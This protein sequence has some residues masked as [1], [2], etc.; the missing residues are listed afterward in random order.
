MAVGRY[1][2]P[3]QAQFMNTY[4]P[5]PFQE[6]LQAGVAKQG[7]QDTRLGQLDAAQQA[8]DAIRYIP[9][10][11]DDKYVNSQVLPVINEIVENYSVGRDLTDPRVFREMRNQMSSID[12]NRVSRVQ[13]SRAAWDK[14]QEARNKLK[15]SG[16]YEPYLDNQ[17]V[18]N[19][20]SESDI[21][22]YSPSAKVGFDLTAESYFNQLRDSHLYTDPTTGKM[23]SGVTQNKV[24]QVAQANAVD[25]L[26]S[27]DGQQA[28]ASLRYQGVEGSDLD[29]ATQYLVDR[30]QEF[31][32][33]SVG[34]APQHTIARQESPDY[35]TG[36]EYFLPSEPLPDNQQ[37]YK[38][39]SR[40]AEDLAAAGDEVK[41]EQYKN[42][43]QTA[44]QAKDEF[45]SQKLTG[46]ETDFDEGINKLFSQNQPYVDMSASEQENL[47]Q[48]LYKA[49]TEDVSV[50]N[51]Y[52][53]LFDTKP[54]MGYYTNSPGRNRADFDKF[55]GKYRKQYDKI[56]K[57]A[58]EHAETVFQSYANKS[59]AQSVIATPPVKMANGVAY[60]YD[61][62]S[63]NWV[64]DASS[65]LYSHVLENVTAQM[66]TP[67]YGTD[68]AGLEVYNQSGSRQIKGGGVDSKGNFLHVTTYGKDKEG[69]EVK[70]GD[71]KVHLPTI[72]QND[73]FAKSF[74]NDGDRRNYIRFSNPHVEAIVE[75]A[76]YA[77]GVDEFQVPVTAN[78]KI[79]ATR[80]QDG[81]YLLRATG[82]DEVVGPLSVD[83]LAPFIYETIFVSSFQK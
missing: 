2:T 32:R 53:E 3:A 42:L 11:Q 27:I 44:D 37:S 38:K 76:T 33:N 73:A 69:T 35:G 54:P 21:Y 62:A 63:G 40:A 13:Q 5:I 14:T 7:I 79:T 58:D 17:D 30:G 18:S 6:I 57:G 49:A 51:A 64:P 68:D 41:A 56:V 55:K 60:S 4:S 45:I 70:T 59:S 1:D 47:T 66:A 77:G 48:A 28:I 80:Q 65:Q 15:L 20:S 24:G 9:G 39:A 82:T 75:Q 67:I 23:V 50:E 34:F 52:K 26:A 43:T 36:F 74:K 78:D 72:T 10:S 25:F 22:N 71:Y 12:R 61:R 31:I 19:F 81:S 29:L 46:F 16:K 83:Q 8:A